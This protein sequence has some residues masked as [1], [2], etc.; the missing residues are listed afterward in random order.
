MISSSPKGPLL[1]PCK[2]PIPCPNLLINYAIRRHF[3]PKI[4]ISKT[5][6]VEI[7]RLSVPAPATVIQKTKCC[8]S[9]SSP[10]ELDREAPSGVK[11]FI[12]GLAQS[13]SEGGLKM[14][15]SQFGEVSRVKI[16]HD[17]KTKQ[18]LGFAY[19]WFTREEHAQAAVEEM[20]GQFFEGRFIRVTF[21]KPGSCKPRPKPGP[22][23]F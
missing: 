1:L 9:L 5:S 8:S 20:N 7:S 22:Y 16:I 3:S 13:T 18:S 10:G 17:K 21:A 12:K 2:H 23:K 19:V 15:F 11:I 6:N 14:A 4:S